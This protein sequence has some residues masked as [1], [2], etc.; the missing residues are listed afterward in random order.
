MSKK[1]VP[2]KVKDLQA[3]GYYSDTLL[4]FETISANLEAVR[5]TICYIHRCEGFAKPVLQIQGIKLAHTY[6]KIFRAYYEAI[7]GRSKEYGLTQES[8]FLLH[9]EVSAQLSTTISFETVYKALLVGDVRQLLRENNEFQPKD[10]NGLRPAEIYDADFKVDPQF[11]CFEDDPA[12]EIAVHAGIQRRGKP[13]RQYLANFFWPKRETGS[14]ILVI[15]FAIQT[16]DPK[17]L[18][19]EGGMD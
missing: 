14:P 5:N 3:H 2:A 10:R 9:N 17:K 7:L 18:K 13:G 4:L 12:F 8:Q 16:T 6:T 15:Y 11:L 19:A 1:E